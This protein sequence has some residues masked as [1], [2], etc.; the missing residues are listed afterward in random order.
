MTVVLDGNDSVLF[1]DDV[2]STGTTGQ[3]A[4]ELAQEALKALGCLTSTV[5]VAT[6]S[7][8]LRADTLPDVPPD[9]LPPALAFQL[10][11]IETECPLAHRLACIV[12]ETPCSSCTP[13]VLRAFAALL[14]SELGEKQLDAILA[15]IGGSSAPMSHL[16]EAALQGAGVYGR[17]IVVAAADVQA[18]SANGN[19]DFR[20]AWNAFLQ[21]YSPPPLGQRVSIQYIG[22][23]GC[24]QNRDGFAPTTLWRAAVAALGQP[25]ARFFCL[26][27]GHDRACVPSLSAPYAV[28]RPHA[29]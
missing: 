15:R 4:S 28:L 16:F 11:S 6:V 27:G 24:V 20:T 10:A 19:T 7:W 5:T 9:D 23:T 8:S 12:A 13:D 14:L 25:E 29:G 2:V 17:E 26:P 3:A 21:A 22:E 1:L 18:V